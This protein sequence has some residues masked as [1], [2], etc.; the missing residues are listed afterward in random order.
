MNNTI[1]AAGHICLDI[2]PF[3]PVKSHVSLTDIFTPGKLTNV[4]TACLS[5]GGAVANTGG[6]LA[7]MGFDVKLNGKI[8]NDEFGR[9]IKNIVGPEAARSFTV[10]NGEQTS[11]SVVL[12]IPGFD[13]MFLHCPGCNDT[14]SA[15]DIDYEAAEQCGIFHFGYP[16]LMAA[17]FA[18]DGAECENMFR[19][20]KQKST[21]TSMDLTLPD[22]QSP[23]GK[24]DWKK[25]LT[26]TFK[27]L[28][29][30]VPSAEEIA[31]MLNRDL[32]KRCQETAR[33]NSCDPVEAYSPTDCISLLDEMLCL[34]VKIAGIKLGAKG[35]MLKTASLK[36]IESLQLFDQQ[37]ASQWADRLLWG[38]TF[39]VDKVVSAT[40]AG[41]AAIAGLLGAIAKNLKPEQAILAANTAGAMNVRNADALSGIGNWNEITKWIDGKGLDIN[42]ACP[43]ETLFKPAELKGVFQG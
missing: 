7:K 11:Y 34:G 24:A 33:L 15:D 9:I 2:T 8:G 19:R 4:D 1:M 14:F 27:Y 29:I 35:L 17:I 21:V 5:T 18:K 23:S 25:I 39:K 20:V 6:S 37:T 16:T 38:N 31:Y 13:R 12:A 22:P 41:D 40:G 28:D 26:S 36:D 3:I 43:D 30:F 10:V 42:T 32:F